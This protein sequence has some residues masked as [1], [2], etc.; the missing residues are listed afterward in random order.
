[1]ATFRSR[2]DKWL[3][4]VQIKGHIAF[5]NLRFYGLTEYKRLCEVRFQDYK[6]T[7]KIKFLKSL[8]TKTLPGYLN[9][10]EAQERAL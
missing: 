6:K 1:M 3:A 10:L 5:S 2:G 8:R 4:W 7:K 9:L